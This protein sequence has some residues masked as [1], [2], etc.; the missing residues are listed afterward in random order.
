MGKRSLNYPWIYSF[1]DLNFQGTEGDTFLASN[2]RPVNIILGGC[3][4]SLLFEVG[5]PSRSFLTKSRKST[6]K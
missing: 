1:G 3:N 4:R 5:T 6:P 2:Y